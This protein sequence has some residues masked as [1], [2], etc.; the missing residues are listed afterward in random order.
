MHET[1]VRLGLPASSDYHG[2]WLVVAGEGRIEKKLNLHGFDYRMHGFYVADGVT[3]RCT[4]LKDVE[5]NAN[6]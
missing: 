3:I 1:N 4:A 6:T 5:V 2:V